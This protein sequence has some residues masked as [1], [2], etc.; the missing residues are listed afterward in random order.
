MC[1][2]KGRKEIGFSR[3]YRK[4]NADT[5]EFFRMLHLVFSCSLLVEEGIYKG[6]FCLGFLSQNFVQG[7]N[8]LTI[9]TDVVVCVC[10]L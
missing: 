7:V 1:V 8:V 4:V 10:D 3:E 9:D 6:F 5:W 2:L